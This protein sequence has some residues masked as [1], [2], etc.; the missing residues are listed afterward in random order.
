MLSSGHELDLSRDLCY[1]AIISMIFTSFVLSLYSTDVETEVKLH[2]SG[3]ITQNDKAI[4]SSSF[5][6]E[7]DVIFLSYSGPS[8]DKCFLSA[9]SSK[10][11]KG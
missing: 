10:A 11:G 7:S 8:K 6:I 5:K 3:L 2:A 1:L 4:E 9:S